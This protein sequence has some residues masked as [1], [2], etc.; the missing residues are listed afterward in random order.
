DKRLLIGENEFAQALRVL[1]REGNTLSPVI[2]QAWDTG[3]LRT[4]VKNNPARATGA[5]ISIV[6][7]I[8]RQELAKYLTDTEIFNGFANRFIWVCIKRSKL[9]PNGGRNVDLSSLGAKLKNA[10]A[11]ATSIDLMARNPAATRLW[12]NV[13][14]SLTAE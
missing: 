7:H 3:D 2:R 9:L 11:M 13:Y 6:G 1:R 5:H 14:P 10:L 8:T 4:L 12:R